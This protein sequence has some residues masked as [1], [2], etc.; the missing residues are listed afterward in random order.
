MIMSGKKGRGDEWMHFCLIHFDGHAEALKQYMWYRPMKHVQGYTRSHW[1]LPSG[2]YSLHIAPSAARATM[3]NVP[4]LLAVSIAIM[5]R[6]CDTE[7]IAWW[8]RSRAFINAT[9]CHH[10]ASTCFNSITRSSQ[11]CYLACFCVG[12]GTILYGVGNFYL[13]VWHINLTERTWRME[14]NT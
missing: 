13:E 7:H 9:K 8:R 3:Q 6:R 1:T 11:C 12:D 5:M 2:N 4:T 10:R 14:W